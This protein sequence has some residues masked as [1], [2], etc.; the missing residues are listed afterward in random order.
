MSDSKPIK[1]SIVAHSHSFVAA[2]HA[3]AYLK[4]RFAGL[5]QVSY[6]VEP[7]GTM[8]KLVLS[9]DTDKKGGYE[10]TSRVVETARAFLAG[11]GAIS[12][13]S[14]ETQRRGER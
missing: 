3:G 10:F 11:A 1:R 2:D 9:C 12:W 4:S 13:A 6:A 7:D 14:T 8:W 5:L